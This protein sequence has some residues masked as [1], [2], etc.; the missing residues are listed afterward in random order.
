MEKDFSQ[1][2]AFKVKKDEKDF[3]FLSFANEL[4]QR[5]ETKERETNLFCCLNLSSSFLSFLL[6]FGIFINLNV[7]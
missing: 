3:F 5:R 1:L 6:H 7:C 2:D 4:Q